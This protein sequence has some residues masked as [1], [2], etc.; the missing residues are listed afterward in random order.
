MWLAHSKK[1]K[2]KLW[3]HPQKLKIL[4]KDEVPLPL[5]QLNRWE[6]EDFGQNIWD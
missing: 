5:A 6:G 2:F 3:K 1:K 4:W